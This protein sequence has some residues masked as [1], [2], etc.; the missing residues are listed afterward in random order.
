MTR[1]ENGTYGEIVAHLERELELDALEESDD[2]PMATRPW[3]LLTK[4]ICY[5]TALTLTRT[6]NA[7]IAKLPDTTIKIASNSRRKRNWRIKMAKSPNVQLTQ[8]THPA[9]KR[10]TP[11]KDAGKGQGHIYVPKGCTRMIKLMTTLERK[12]S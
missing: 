12:R 10:T 6:P 2:L 3:R 4:V 1:L 11:L 7:P 9:G 5:P 8:N